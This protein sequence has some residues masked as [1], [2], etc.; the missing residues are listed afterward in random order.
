[1]H[2][3]DQVALADEL[4]S[5]WKMAQPLAGKHYWS[6]RSWGM[7]MWQP[8]YLSV[9]AIYL[10]QVALDLNGIW[11]ASRAGKTCGFTLPEQA[12]HFGTQQEMI[13]AAAQSLLRYHQR[14]HAH[15][16]ATQ[17]Y[18]AKQAACMTV[19]CVLSALLLPHRQFGWSNVQLARQRDHWLE[20]LKLPRH[21]NLMFIP[22]HNTAVPALN[23]QGC[24]QHFR[25][26]GE[27]AC[28]TCPRWPMPERIRRIK[29]ELV[30]FQ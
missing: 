8:A 29:Q 25:I 13:N 14:Q 28:S 10:G 22:L 18:S 15:F 7:L 24:C 12:T 3:G 5:H 9:L 11:Q 26:P 1:M 27:A 4:F 23:R 6:A 30:E 17:A 19:D 21:G 16:N 2:N 20:A